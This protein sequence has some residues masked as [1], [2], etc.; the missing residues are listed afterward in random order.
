MKTQKPILANPKIQRLQGPLI[1]FIVHT[2][3]IFC[4]LKFVT[5]KTEENVDELAVYIHNR[6]IIEI[7]EVLP[8]EVQNIAELEDE[9]MSVPLEAP[10]SKDANLDQ[11]EEFDFENL[12][13]DESVEFNFNEPFVN[14]PLSNL[15]EISELYKTRT[16]KN[17]SNVLNKFG[18]SEAGQDALLNALRWLKGVQLENG[19]WVDKPAHTA[20]AILSFLAH[21]D[22][23]LSAEF[24][25]SI[26]NALHFLVKSMP[27]D[28]TFCGN[29]AY[30][31]GITTYALSEA[32]GITNIPFIKSAMDYGVSKIVDGQHVDGGYDYK[33]KKG[34]RWD[35]SIAGWQIQALKAAYA[36]GSDSPGILDA[37]EKST[38]FVKSTYKNGKFGYSS[39]GSGGNMTGVGTLCLQLLGK[40]KSLEA[41]GGYNTIISKRIR[42][43]Q[44]IIDES[45]WSTK[46]AKHLY[47]WYYETQAVFHEGG[48]EWRKWNKLFQNV[49][50]KN[51][52][53]D[54]HWQVNKASYGF[55][56]DLSGK[57]YCT[58]LCCLQLSVYYRYL[59]T[60]KFVKENFLRHVKFDITNHNSESGIIIE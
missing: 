44:N 48:N 3:V 51:Q 58:T 20:L 27:T 50:L 17:R 28:G 8:M 25:S 45:N 4:L 18:G 24:G 29:S 23:T 36:A 52:H 10:V 33:Y 19:S 22:T 11:L 55:K 31:H 37:L 42:K 32:Y 56:N 35:L 12:E 16:T 54:G 6:E 26:Q 57:V 1:S 34:K 39:P 40:S 7:E 46:A 13:M 30:V 15:Y 60:Y 49:L 38:R 14:E 21:G 59:P 41:R 5:M 47:G 9:A 53:D 2:L 43:L